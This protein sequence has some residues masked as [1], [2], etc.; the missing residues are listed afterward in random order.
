M[1]QRLAIAVGQARQRCF[2]LTLIPL[3]TTLLIIGMVTLSQA[4]ESLGVPDRDDIEYPDDDPPSEEEVRLGK[5]L[6]FDRRLSGNNRLSCAS[7]HNPDLG[8]GD[9]LAL[10][11]GAKGNRLTR[12]T[13]H[14]YNF[15][16]NTTFLWDGRAASL[17]EQVLGPIANCREMSMP[18]DQLI[19]KLKAVPVY[20]EAFANL[21]PDMGIVPETVARAI[22]AFERTLISDNSPFDHYMNGEKS[23]MSA[24]AVRSMK[25]FGSMKLFEGKA[26]CTAC[27]SG[28]NFTN[29]SFHNVGLGD[30]DP[31]R[32]AI[33]DDDT[34]R[35]AFKTP[36][37]RNV[38]LTAPYMHDGSIATLEAVVQFYNAGERKGTT[39]SDLIKP[40][41]LSEAE[42]FDLVA[43]LGALTDPVIITRP[44]MPSGPDETAN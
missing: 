24:A 30:T 7:C 22:A 32:A 43:F 27:H 13:P 10:G 15:T 20:R 18:L 37:L 44:E 42:I 39:T 8:F 34:L 5:L 3:Y 17:E 41:H 16:W 33:V 26:N 4:G 31:A 14:L 38:L 25:L 29:E 36:G 1:L 23:A 2:S 6:F 11:L 35:G 21:Y 12:H 19:G 28:P 40:L 9:G